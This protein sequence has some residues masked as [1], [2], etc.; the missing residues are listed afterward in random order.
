MRSA[1]NADIDKVCTRM[2]SLTKDFDAAHDKIRHIESWREKQTRSW[3]VFLNSALKVVLTVAGGVGVV[4]AV[5]AL[6]L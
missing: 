4:L 3:S 6:G 5:K 2:E 1:H